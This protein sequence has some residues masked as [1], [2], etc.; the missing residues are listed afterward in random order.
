[1]R[2]YARRRQSYPFPADHIVRRVEFILT[3]RRSSREGVKHGVAVFRFM[4]F[5]HRQVADRRKD[6]YA[7]ELVG[8]RPREPSLDCLAR[9][10]VSHRKSIVESEVP[11]LL[12]GSGPRQQHEKDEDVKPAHVRDSLFGVRER[13]DPVLQAG[14]SSGDAQMTRHKIKNTTR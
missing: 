7:L 2:F 6:F 8:M 11:T 3:L 9:L 13:I 14:L 12:R 5:L 4:R 10:D 1:M